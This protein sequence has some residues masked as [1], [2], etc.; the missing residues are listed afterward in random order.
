MAPA[1]SGPIRVVLAAVR[2]ESA[3]PSAMD[4]RVLETASS[5]AGMTGA[6]LHVAHFWGV[7]GESV[8]AS[9]TRGVRRGRLGRVLEGVEREQHD[10]LEALLADI[11]PDVDV[12]VTVAKGDAARG[13]ARLAR[14]I[15]ADVVVA[16]NSA[17][18]GVEGVLFGNLTERL[19]GRVTGA[20]L[21]L[22]PEPKGD[23]PRARGA[24]RR[25]SAGGSASPEAGAES[26]EWRRA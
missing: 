21:A 17:R 11:A 6:R 5:L 10:R 24:A 25:H 16:G 2:L 1:Q 18:S 4:H 22:R 3:E 8:L 20:V 26:G 9:P 23:E 7:L 12:E 19:L 13:V 15:Q 14:R